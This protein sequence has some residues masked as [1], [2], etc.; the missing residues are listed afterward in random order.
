MEYSTMNRNFV[1]A[2][3]HD[4]KKVYAWTANDEDVMTRMIFYGVD[5]I[6]TDQ[7]SLLNETM[8]TDLENPT[9]SDKLL[10]FAIGMG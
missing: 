9:Y 4:G 3:H 7:L 6:I 2:A 1:N 8:K 10:N 5:G